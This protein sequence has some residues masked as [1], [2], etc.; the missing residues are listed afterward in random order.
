MSLSKKSQNRHP[1][2]LLKWLAT[3]FGVTF[4]CLVCGVASAKAELTT[5]LIVGDSLSAS[6]GVPVEQGWVALIEDKIQDQQ[7]Q[8]KVINASISGDTTA[9]GLARIEKLL[10]REQPDWVLIELGA[11][12]GLRGLPVKAMRQNLQAM[13]DKV[14]ASG[15]KALLAGIKIPPNYGSR[16]TEL[17]EKAFRDTAEHN[18]IPLLPFLL[19]GVAGNSALMQSDGLHPNAEAQSLIAGHVWQFLETHLAPL[20]KS[21]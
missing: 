6:Y 7:A 5:L 4:I 3:Y 14:E 21:P 8:L 17:F 1:I 2:K 12:D 13:I 15:A 9:G 20:Q 11:N 16:Y 19:E 18:E 10:Y